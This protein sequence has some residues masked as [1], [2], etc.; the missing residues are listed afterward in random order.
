MSLGVGKTGSLY[1]TLKTANN[2]QSMNDRLGVSVVLVLAR[3]IPGTYTHHN[4]NRCIQM[5]VQGYTGICVIYRYICVRDVSS[6]P[7]NGC[8]VCGGMGIL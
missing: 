4:D 1:Y 7:T 6:Q 3:N 2:R 8:A 5:Y